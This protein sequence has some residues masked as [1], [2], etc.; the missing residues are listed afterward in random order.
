MTLIASMPGFIRCEWSI[1]Y[2]T[3]RLTIQDCRTPALPRIF[4]YR[5]GSLAYRQHCMRRKGPRL[6]SPFKERRTWGLSLTLGNHQR[7]SDS[8]PYSHISRQAGQRLNYRH[9]RNFS[10]GC[11]SQCLFHHEWAAVVHLVPIK[12]QL[13]SLFLPSSQK[14]G[15]CFSKFLFTYF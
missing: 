6:D 15:W 14:T 7:R 13:L 10:G 2:F 5:K 1:S 8:N 4:P 12:A 3:T 11:M 9:Q